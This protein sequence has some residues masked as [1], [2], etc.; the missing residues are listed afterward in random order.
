MSQKK[1]DLSAAALGFFGGAIVLALILF[2]ISRMTSQ[3]Y[4]KEAAAAEH[5]AP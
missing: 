3:K 5:K 1:T 4:E 2:G